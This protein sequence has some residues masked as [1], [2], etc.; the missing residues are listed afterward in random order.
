MFEIGQK[1]VTNSIRNLSS[2]P[3]GSR[4]EIVREL[5]PSG[6][7]RVFFGHLAEDFPNGLLMRDKEIRALPA[8]EQ[9]AEAADD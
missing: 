8:L 1:V 9:L 5:R 3:T 6:Y 2:L 7:Y 4:G